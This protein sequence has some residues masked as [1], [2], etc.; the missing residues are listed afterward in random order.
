[1]V[2]QAFT[3][4]PTVP[5]SNEL[6]YKKS[7]KAQHWS[8]KFLVSDMSA[9][10]HFYKQLPPVGR[11]ELMQQWCSKHI[12]HVTQRRKLCWNHISLTLPVCWNTKHHIL[13]TSNFVTTEYFK[14]YNSQVMG[15]Q[16][17]NKNV[18]TNS[19]LTKPCQKYWSFIFSPTI[20]IFKSERNL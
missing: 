3:L 12:I 17:S 9:T 4:T 20:H 15:I 13:N 8:D 1:M 10:L 6:W 18:H 14:A 2:Y 7:K 19:Y 16:A 11:G 5:K